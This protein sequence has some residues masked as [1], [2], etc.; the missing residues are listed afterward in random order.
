MNLEK[1][2][3]PVTF[4]HMIAPVSSLAAYSAV[5][6]NFASR[7]SFKLFFF[8]LVT[9]ATVGT[10]RNVVNTIHP[11][12]CLLLTSCYVAVFTWCEYGSSVS[13][14]ILCDEYSMKAS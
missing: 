6:Y 5:F 13:S 1:L 4:V 14:S 12:M 11:V 8:V 9:L 3:F 10:F 2:F 7:A